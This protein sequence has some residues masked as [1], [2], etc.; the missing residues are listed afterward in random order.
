MHRSIVLLSAIALLAC[1]G[2]SGRPAIFGGADAPAGMKSLPAGGS[3]QVFMTTLSGSQSAKQL[4]Q[5]LLRGVQDY[6]GG[7]A[8]ILQAIADPGDTR[9][10]AAFRAQ[11]DGRPV[12]G[13]LAI[14]V[15][16][17]SA[18][19]V[20]VFDE[21]PAFAGSIDRLMS[22]AMA[23]NSGDSARNP[24]PEPLVRTP[25]PD[26]SGNIDL[27]QGWVIRYA[28]QG[29]LDI[30][31]PTP[32]SGMSLGAV[33]PVPLTSLDPLEALRIGTEQIGQAQGK[34]LEL[35]ILDS[36]PMEWAQGGRAALIRYRIVAD[37]QPMDYFAL[38]GVTP[39]EATQMFLYTSYVQATAQDFPRVF[40]TAMRTWASWSINPAVFA[41]RMQ[42]AAQS[43][44]AT[45][46][47]LTGGG[48]S[49]SRAFDGVNAGWGQY[50]RG[51][52]T[53]E[54]GD[55]NRSE[56]D[57]RFA[58]SVVQNDPNNFRIVPTSELV[59]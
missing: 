33:A 2:G 36:K 12:M 55:R 24:E 18:P 7:S 58:E 31:G 52:A 43:M 34:R 47:L 3:G 4:A 39:F 21:A 19:A 26:G 35:T 57:Q 22:V 10:Q 41:Q 23:N 40:P 6:F 38:I 48:S 50:I 9:V 53:L 27:A 45:G 51:V 56:V 11:R 5:G 46:E 8:E 14:E 15:R 30:Q 44:R 29:A 13:M 54:D 17:G 25:I 1:S 16:G 59:P 28:R 37:G 32:G 20:L 42:S 49:S